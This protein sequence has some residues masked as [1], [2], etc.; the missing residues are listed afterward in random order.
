MQSSHWNF[1]VN[2]ANLNTNIYVYVYVCIYMS[3]ILHI[4]I[5]LGVEP[6]WDDVVAHF[7]EVPHDF[8]IFD[9][10]MVYLC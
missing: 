8:S 1:I 9:Y 10:S 4:F 3:L 5:G 6:L 7:L 2:P